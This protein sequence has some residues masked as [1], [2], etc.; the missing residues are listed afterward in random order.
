MT[1][2]HADSLQA[3]A[4]CL[5]RYTALVSVCLSTYL[6]ISSSLS[7]ELYTR[8]DKIVRAMTVGDRVVVVVVVVVVVAAVAAAVITVATALAVG[9]VLVAAAAIIAAALAVVVVIMTIRSRCGS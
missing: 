4:V 5:P 6:S 8:S 2:T 1:S 3:A 9:V 7:L